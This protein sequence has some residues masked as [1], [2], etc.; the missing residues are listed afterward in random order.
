MPRGLHCCLEAVPSYPWQFEVLVQ[1]GTAGDVCDSGV[2]QP[3]EVFG[4]GPGKAGVVNPDGGGAGQGAADAYNWTAECQQ[5]LDFGVAE[6]ER[7]RDDCVEPLPEYPT[8]F[9][10]R[11][12]T[13]VPPA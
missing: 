9:L 11:N 6:D 13:A 5:L 8:E 2:A 4:G 1:F 12:S 10:I 3:E 7:Y